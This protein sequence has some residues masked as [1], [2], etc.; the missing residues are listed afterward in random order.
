MLL[1]LFRAEADPIHPD[2]TVVCLEDLSL[3]RRLGLKGRGRKEISLRRGERRCLVVPAGEG[4]SVRLPRRAAARPFL[5]IGS[6]CVLVRDPREKSRIREIPF[7][8]SGEGGFTEIL[9][10]RHT[11]RHLHPGALPARGLPHHPGRGGRGAAGVVLIDGVH[12]ISPW[13]PDFDPAYET[14]PAFIDELAAA[15]PGVAVVGLT[16]RSRIPTR[17]RITERLGMG[18]EPGPEPVP[19]R[20]NLSLQVVRTAGAAE[21]NDAVDRAIQTDIPAALGVGEEESA[22]NQTDRRMGLLVQPP[23]AP[24]D[25]TSARPGKTAELLRAVLIRDDLD[26]ALPGR[27]KKRISAIPTLTFRPE[28]LHPHGGVSRDSPLDRPFDPAPDPGRRDL[29]IAADPSVLEERDRHIRFVLQDGL[30]D[31]LTAWWRRTARAGRDGGRAHALHL[32]APPDPRCEAEM[33]GRGSDRPACS[34]R[35]CP[36]RHEPPCDYGRAYSVLIDSLPDVV[37]GTVRALRTADRLAAVSDRGRVVLSVGGDAAR[38]AETTEGLFW[39]SAVGVVEGFRCLGGGRFSAWGFSAEP[40]PRRVEGAVG[41]FLGVEASPGPGLFDL[42]RE[43]DR[44]GERYGREFAASS[45]RFDVA[46]SHPG[47]Y[48]AVRDHLPVL[49]DRIREDL[50]QMGSRSLRHLRRFFRE[51]TCL[52][53]ALAARFGPVAGGWTC[54]FCARCAPDLDVSGVAARPIDP[55]EDPEGFRG[56]FMDWLSDP[57]V[58]FDPDRAQGRLQRFASY[59]ASIRAIS[60]A[61][62]EISPKNLNALYLERESAPPEER[63]VAARDLLATAVRTLPFEPV[64]RLYA[65]S[66]A[67]FQGRLFELMDDEYGAAACPEGERWLHGEAARLAVEPGRAAMLGVRR[68]V[69]VLGRI[70]LAGVNERLRNL[71]EEW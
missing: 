19:A 9:L 54:G 11:V 15:R 24:P 70:D 51:E 22:Y 50:E 41:R 12:R 14:L 38:S 66:P 44:A 25:G 58:P 20:S 5:V 36:Y 17:R 55:G 6:L 68:M 42:D 49:L 47:L 45:G 4:R 69:D 18:F 62:S 32:V 71:I 33:A 26:P 40:D 48:R 29:L 53:A 3:A 8:G 23:A 64:R 60:G 21:R 27:M 39:M 35:T 10:G 13:E 61:A 1:T 43:A 7:P 67:E 63:N 31:D 16:D 28:Y 52:G 34:R 57:A 65:S 46:R 59:A 37:D 56:E 2:R 30:A